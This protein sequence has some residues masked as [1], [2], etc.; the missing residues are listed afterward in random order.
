MVLLQP[1]SGHK[2]RTLGLG[3]VKC[4]LSFVN[5][6]LLLDAAVLQFTTRKGQTAQS[7]TDFLAAQ[8]LS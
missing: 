2:R 8:Q 6:L 5:P 3:Q 7:C 4:Q 1:G